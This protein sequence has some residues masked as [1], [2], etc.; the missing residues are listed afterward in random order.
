[1][2]CLREKGRARLGR[3]WLGGQRAEEVV[4]RPQHPSPELAKQHIVRGGVLGVVLQAHSLEVLDGVLLPILQGLAAL[5]AE[6]IAVE[7]QPAVR[8]PVGQ[9][10]SLHA[11]ASLRKAARGGVGSPG[12]GQPTLYSP[13]QQREREQEQSQACAM[14]RSLHSKRG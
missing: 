10:P 8:F 5:G 13:K 6:R 7:R 4:A 3:G 2:P 11:E 12:D 9:E 1:M 14:H